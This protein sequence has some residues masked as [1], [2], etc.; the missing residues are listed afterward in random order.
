MSPEANAAVI[1]GIF[2]VVTVLA[3]VAAQLYGSYKTSKDT[4]GTL[5]TQLAEQRD[6]LNTT[7]AQQ[8][9]QTLN[10]RFATAADQLGSDKPAA[11]RLAGV[12]AMA[13]LADDW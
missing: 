1:A 5:E 2:G 11:V 9:D 3:T 6:E 8:R 12:Y 7:L 13:G 10:E 4:R